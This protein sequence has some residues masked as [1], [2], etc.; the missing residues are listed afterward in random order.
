[1]TVQLPP[2]SFFPEGQKRDEYLAFLKHLNLDPDAL[3]NA[4]VLMPGLTADD[5]LEP[6]APKKDAP[7]PTTWKLLNL[8]HEEDKAAL[9]HSVESSREAWYGTIT[10]QLVPQ[11]QR[12]QG[13]IITAVKNGPPLYAA[14]R[15]TAVVDSFQDDWLHTLANVYAQVSGDFA[16]QV[17]ASLKEAQPY[18]VKDDTAGDLWKQIVL[19]WLAHLAGQ[20]ISSI[21]DTTRTDVRNALQ[22][23]VAAGEGIPKLVKRLLVLGTFS[24]DR[25]EKISR[26]EVIAAS[27]LGSQAAARSTGLKLDHAWLA[28]RDSRTREAHAEADGQRVALD[29][30]FIV[31]GQK[32]MFPGDTSL[33]ATGAMVI[34]CRCTEVYYTEGEP[35]DE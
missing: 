34:R 21:L 27:N 14:Q 6:P 20:K 15:A 26:T 8:H 19:D 9:W 31:G 1:M 22:A 28:T 24:R 10:D 3:E 7:G 32:L 13:Q 30:P 25:A 23:G 5:V 35:S 16:A 4:D 29:K 33:G 17:L 18:E 12:E 11:L 2:P